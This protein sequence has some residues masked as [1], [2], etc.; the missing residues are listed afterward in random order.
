MRGRGRKGGGGGGGGNPLHR[1]YESNGPDVK[2]RGTASQIVEKYLQLARDAA[3]SGDPVA[4]ESYLQ[5]AEHYFRI[6]AAATPPEQRQQNH[7]GNQNRY[8]DEDDGDEDNNDA[9]SNA[10]AGR[11]HANGSRQAPGSGDQPS[12]LAASQAEG[13]DEGSVNGHDAARE[14]S[15]Q[16][17]APRPKR[18]RGR[19]RRRAAVESDNAGEGGE[20]D[21]APPASGDDAMKAVAEA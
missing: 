21:A 13:D 14:E 18:G 7:D 8:G 6:V 11:Q 20:A 3:A 10:N 4:S 9:G 19:P 16:D 5:H 2:V 1:S 12:E 15:Q 17:E